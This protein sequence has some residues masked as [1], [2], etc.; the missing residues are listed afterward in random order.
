[1]I[2]TSV[3]IDKLEQVS[4]QIFNLYPTYTVWLLNGPMGA[5]KTTFAKSICNFLNCITQ[6]S[7]PSFGIVNEY[8]TSGMHSIYHFDCYRFRSEDEAYDIGMEEYLDSG[9]LCLIEWAEKIP[10]L[11]PAK[12]L[13]I[14]INVDTN[15]LRTITVK[16]HG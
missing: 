3:S 13:I 9:N 15:T 7:S 12:Y 2:F 10:N 1:M 4:E 8:Q 16:T 6:A 5:G 14:D 11:L